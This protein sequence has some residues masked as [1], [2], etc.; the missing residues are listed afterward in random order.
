[1]RD[2][3]PG[4]AHEIVVADAQACDRKIG[5]EHAALDAKDCQRVGHDATI[6]FVV[7]WLV[8]EAELG[9]LQMDVRTARNRFH[10]VPP[11]AQA[12]GASIPR[13]SGVIQ[14]HAYPRKTARNIGSFAQMPGRYP[15]IPR[16]VEFLEQRQTAKPCRILHRARH[17]GCHFRRRARSHRFGANTANQRKTRVLRQHLVSIAGVEP[18]MADDRIR[19]AVQPIHLRKPARLGDLAVA[20]HLRLD[21]HCRKHIVAARIALV[22]VR[23][24]VSLERIVVAHEKVLFRFVRQPRVT[25]RLEI[26][27]VMMRIDQRN[28][29]GVIVPAAMDCRHTHECH[30]FGRNTSR[31]AASKAVLI[32]SPRHGSSR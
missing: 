21:M 6:G 23:Q 7:P 24:I 11:V 10:R 8:L 12:G 32:W 3:P 4:G 22:V 13:K 28:R 1:M 26:P 25:I 15:E 29:P 2:H 27:E 20:S 31:F 5:R 18:D 16:E 14:N 9:Y 17:S 19:H 30:P